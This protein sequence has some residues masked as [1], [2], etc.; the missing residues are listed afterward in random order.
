[1]K[2]PLLPAEAL[3]RVV[4]VARFD[5]MSVL[6]L[7]GGFALLSAGSK[8]V[9][10]AVIGLLIAGAGALELHGSQLLRAG[11]DGMRW[12]IGSQLYLL[13]IILCY[14]GYRL[15]H[16]DIAWMM[17]YMSGEAAEPFKEAAAQQGMS[18]PQLLTAAMEMFYILVAGLTILYQGAMALYY[19]RRRQVVTVALQEYLE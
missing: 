6:S 9:T 8:D 4:R 1:M 7:S 10:G 19:V 17:P 16:P 18:V 12:L 14:V 2:P 15:L 13:G 3:K 11:A 5:G